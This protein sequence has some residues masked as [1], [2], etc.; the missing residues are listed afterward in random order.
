[1][2]SILL[3]D[4]IASKRGRL[5]L[6][7]KFGAKVNIADSNGM[8]LLDHAIVKNEYDVVRWILD[9]TDSN[10][11]DKNHALPDGRN[12]SHLSRF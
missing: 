9:R 4:T 6:L 1:M 12:A 10:G 8:T 11:F 3:D 7:D 2:I 5:E